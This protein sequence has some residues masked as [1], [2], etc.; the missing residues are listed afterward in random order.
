MVIFGEHCSGCIRPFAL[1]I[2]I[3]AADFL[4]I[5]IDDN[6]AVLRCGA[7]N[8][9]IGIVGRA[10]VNTG[11]TI[12][13]CT[14]N[15]ADI[16]SNLGNCRP[17]RFTIINIQFEI[18][19]GKNSAIGACCLDIIIMFAGGLFRQT[20][21]P[22]AIRTDNA[23]VANF[24]LFCSIAINGDSRAC[25][26][27]AVK[28]GRCIIGMTAIGNRAFNR[29]H[30]VNS[31]INRYGI[32]I[33][34]YCNIGC[35]TTIAFIAGRIFYR[36]GKM[37]FAFIKRRCRCERPRTI[38]INFRLADCFVT[39]INGHDIT[40]LRI[41]YRA[42][43]GGRCVVCCSV[44]GAVIG[45]HRLIRGNIACNCRTSG[46]S[47]WSCI[48]HE[49]IR[50][51][52][53]TRVAAG[54]CCLNPDIM[55]S[56]SKF[57]QTCFPMAV[58]IDFYGLKQRVLTI[59]AVVNFNIRAFCTGSFDK[60]R[61]VARDPV[62]LNLV[63]RKNNIRIIIMANLGNRRSTGRMPDKIE[64]ENIGFCFAH[65]AG[66]VDRNHPETVMSRHQRTIR[67]NLPRTVTIDSLLANRLG[68]RV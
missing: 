53:R 59:Y 46:T 35:K 6:K 25:R 30:I 7:F 29:I 14:L 68:V 15:K 5:I 55:G 41:I 61:I 36:G 49:R 43:E 16:I 47:R 4:A 58:I 42:R 18:L 8:R 26:C 17:V 3:N 22:F 63:I 50:C 34:G 57:L 11:A 66:M 12:C 44:I 65:H 1:A 9:R 38:R 13:N 37:M 52:C 67:F 48:H 2:G 56:F 23:R 31:I 33:I 32:S 19:S 24:R 64:L 60:R 51:G 27:R 20:D 62:L 39:I 21:R 28:F 54:I 45:D 40:R 10:I